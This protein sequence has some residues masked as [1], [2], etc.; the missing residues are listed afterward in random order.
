MNSQIDV[1]ATER[2][3]ELI[4]CADAPLVGARASIGSDIALVSLPQRDEAA[5]PCE[6]AA[7]EVSNERIT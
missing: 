1:R 7:G 2:V 4:E 5:T 3:A 6:V